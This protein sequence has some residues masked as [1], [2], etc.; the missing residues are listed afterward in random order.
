MWVNSLSTYNSPWS[1]V[2]LLNL[3]LKVHSLSMI[4]SHMLHLPVS[5]FTHSLSPC[6]ILHTFSI[7]LFHSSHILYLAVSFFTHSL[8]RCFILHTFSISLFHSSHILYLPVSVFTHSL[9]P[10]FSGPFDEF[11]KL[12]YLWS[13]MVGLVLC[14]VPGVLISL[15]T[16][17]S[18]F[19]VC[20]IS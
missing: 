5:V 14:V 6:F 10:C 18:T 19:S 9:S 13:A 16:R 17:M 7:S 3:Y 2:P 15:A 4:S 12:S 8:S 1:M 11:Y 20:L